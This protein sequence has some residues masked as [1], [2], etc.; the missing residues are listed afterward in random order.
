MSRSGGV[1]RHLVMTNIVITGATGVLGRR[2]V[3]ELLAAG[4]Q[5]SRRHPVPAGPALL[6]GLGARAVDADVFDPASLTAAFAG[7]D[8]VVNLL[9]HIP[10]ADQMMAPGAWDEN[11]RL[12][13]EASA[14]IARAAQDAGA[15]AP[16]PGVARLPLRRRR[17]RL[18]RRGRAGRR[19][20]PDRDGPHRRGQ[21][22]GA[23]R[24]RHRRP[25][26]RAL[27]RARQRPHAGDVEAARARDLA[28]PRPARRVPADRLARR[29]R[30]GGRG[31]RGRRARGDLQRGRRGPA[32]PRR[33]R[34]GARGRRRARRAA[35]GARRGPAR[36]EPAGALAARLA[37]GG[38]ARRPAGRRACAAAPT[39]GA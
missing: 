18:A 27:H 21:R 2:A 8:T 26:L 11:D 20:R 19:R 30:R 34:R 38:C 24:G 3:R 25:A 15:G 1:P 10:P 31:G 9:T 14:A 5:V 12:R 6:E 39:A 22:D 4:H 28:E 17:R 7:A 37:A 32:D 29:R 23:L 36:L 35:P 33:D 13:R 16:R